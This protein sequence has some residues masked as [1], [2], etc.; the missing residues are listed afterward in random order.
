MQWETPQNLVKFRWG[1]TQQSPLAE[2]LLFSS[3]ALMCTLPYQ[4]GCII[5]NICAWSISASVHL[6]TNIQF[7]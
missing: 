1:W 2:L 7:S 3:N 4:V 6:E 5:S